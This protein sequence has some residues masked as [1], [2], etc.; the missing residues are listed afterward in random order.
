MIRFKVNQSD[1]NAYAGETYIRAGVH[2]TINSV[3][4]SRYLRRARA[5]KK[6]GSNDAYDGFNL[7]NNRR[8]MNTD[9][10]S[11]HKGSAI[12]G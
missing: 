9:K 12:I 7:S 2:E 6:L 1:L 10:A 5:V 3:G 11:I 4:S 8:A